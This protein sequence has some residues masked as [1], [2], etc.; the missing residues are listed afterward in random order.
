MKLTAQQAGLELR[1]KYGNHSPVEEGKEGNRRRDRE[2]EER[3]LIQ[4]S[5]RDPI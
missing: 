3:R 1:R 2:P 4:G 5:L